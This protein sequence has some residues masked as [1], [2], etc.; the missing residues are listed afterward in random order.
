MKI[1]ERAISSLYKNANV[2][3]G[4]LFLRM[5]C[6]DPGADEELSHGPTKTTSQSLH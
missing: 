5:Q 3:I 6:Q 1:V 4:P 2:G